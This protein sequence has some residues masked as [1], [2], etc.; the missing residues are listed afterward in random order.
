VV[1]TPQRRGWVTP[2]SLDS[3]VA[4][5]EEA[6]VANFDYDLVVIGFGRSLAALRAV[7]KG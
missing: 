4:P 7:E 5:R 3:H 1:I 6:G 2:P